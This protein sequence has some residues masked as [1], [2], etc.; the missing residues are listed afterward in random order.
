M[1]KW[2]SVFSP[3]SPFYISWGGLLWRLF[4]YPL[5][6]M[7]TLVRPYYGDRSLRLLK[8]PT[9]LWAEDRVDWVGFNFPSHLVSRFR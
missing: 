5:P 6:P 8:G 9:I 2:I 4:P 1:T 3:D 7:E